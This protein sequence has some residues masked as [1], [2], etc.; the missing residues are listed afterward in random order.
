MI[1]I[2]KSA[3]IRSI[4]MPDLNKWF[5]QEKFENFLF[6]LK[7]RLQC[8]SCFIN[9]QI[10]SAELLSSYIRCLAGSAKKDCESSIAKTFW[11]MKGNREW[12][13]KLF[14]L[15]R[16][17]NCVQPKWIANGRLWDWVIDTCWWGKGDFVNCSTLS[18]TKVFCSCLIDWNSQQNVTNS[19]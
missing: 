17:M 5:I 11:A 16:K 6:K 4:L 1:A 2:K 9:K 19:K 12:N 3:K 14:K 15:K 7:Q 10:Q 8:V 13:I 18:H